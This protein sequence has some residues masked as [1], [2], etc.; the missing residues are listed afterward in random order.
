MLGAEGETN[1]IALS[2]EIEG[3]LLAGP[4]R[5]Q[6]ADAEAEWRS[7]STSRA[8]SSAGESPPP[9]SPS[10]RTSRSLSCQ[11]SSGG[12]GR[13]RSQICGESSGSQVTTLTR[14]ESGAI[15][16]LRYAP[17]SVLL[18]PPLP[19]PRCVPPPQPQRAAAVTL[20]PLPLER[21]RSPGDHG[22]VLTGSVLAK[23]TPRR[24]S[25]PLRGAVAR[26]SPVDAEIGKGG[27]VLHHRRPRG[28]SRP[29]P[30]AIRPR[31]RCR[32]RRPIVKDCLWGLRRA[33]FDLDSLLYLLQ[34]GLRPP[35]GEPHF[36]G[37]LELLRYRSLVLVTQLKGGKLQVKQGA[38]CKTR[39]GARTA[40][41][42]EIRRVCSISLNFNKMLRTQQPLL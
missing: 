13:E 34:R 36:L 23:L 1:A 22:V 8:A 10:R 25:H 31:G 3:R 9:S 4:R 38:G 35:E 7:R 42:R 33:P 18:I 12:R 27:R 2:E 40:A 29:D 14:L 32:W 28:Q 16:Q 11:E 15:V 21:P 6:R 39:I 17:V 30:V 24:R 41:S 5:P 19:V 37:L 20:A 26:G